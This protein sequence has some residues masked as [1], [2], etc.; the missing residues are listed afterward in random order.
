MAK[1]S[2]HG[3]DESGTTAQRPTNADE[4]FKYFDT[5]LNQLITYTGSTWVDVMGGAPA[6]AG[7]GSVPSGQA[8]T[9]VATEY[10]APGGFHRTR[11]TLTDMPQTVTNGTEYQSTQ[12]YDF[13][14][15]RIYVL[16]TVSTLAQKTTSTLASTLNTG[17]TGAIALGTAAAS[18]TTLTSTMVDLAPSTAFTS[19][20]TIN[21]AGTAVSPILTAAA[22][23]DGT[24]T[25]KD[26]YLNSA[27]ATT[28][29]V[30]G[31]AT[32]TWTGTI[33]V[34]WIL[35]GDT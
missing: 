1:T 35:I 17:S 22:Y 15:G 26:M 24:A 18:S 2:L 29:D 12:L 31:D 8:A 21:V 23:F 13:P 27:Y 32:Q 7:A 28:T 19:S 16:G 11:L 5:T 25:A 4:G 9:V 34:I 6:A 20:S 3:H 30:D 10:S 33:D 14:E